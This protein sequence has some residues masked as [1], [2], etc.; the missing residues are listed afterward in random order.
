M[1][2]VPTSE[3]DFEGATATAGRALQLMSEHNVPA[4]PQ[5]FETWFTFALGTA[6]ELTRIINILV[7]NKRAFDAETNRSLFL[8]Y[9]GGEA[10]WT[11]KQVKI[12]EEL[13][14]LVDTARSYLATSI[15]DSR[16][17]VAALGG[18]ASQIKRDLESREIIEG[19]VAELSRSLTRATKLEANFSASLQ[20]LDKIRGTLATVE[21]RSRTDALTGL[22]NRHALDDF[23]RLRQIAAMESGQSLSIFLVD[24]DHFKQFNDRFGHQFGDQVLRLIAQVLQG[25]M[26]D[27]DLA[28]RYGG[29]EMIGILP[30][31]DI[32][33]AVAIAERIRQLIASREIKRRSTGELLSRITVSIGVAQFVPG[34]TLASLF[35]RCDRALY[36]AKR[37]GRNRTVTELELAHGSAAA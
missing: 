28:A 35:E 12:S 31:I 6:P 29:E 1:G 34:E 19:L 37:G 20:E 4:T 2:P 7:A 15:A 10:H 3:T 23:L 17:H 36:A 30:G 13:H 5:N 18:V 22:A 26:R 11:A 25:G 8:S 32:G 9:V 24:V 14:G 27:E 21:Q 33:A 16:D